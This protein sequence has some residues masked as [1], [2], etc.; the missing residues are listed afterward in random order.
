MIKPLTSLRFFFA[1]IVFC[2]HLSFFRN[3]NNETLKNIYYGILKEGYLGVSFF[4]ILSGFILAYNYQNKFLEKKACF[5][6]FVFARWARIYPLHLITFFIAI[7][8]T[9]SSLGESPYIWIKKALSNLFLIHSFS[10]D[11]STYFSFN[12]VSW[13]I[14][15]EWF[16]YIAFPFI[17]YLISKIKHTL[18]KILI[19]SVIILIPILFYILLPEN[20]KLHHSLFYVNPLFRVIDFFIGIFLFN[21]FTNQK[22]KSFFNK[23]SNIL[24]FSSL[25][26]FLLFFIFHKEVNQ[27]L[28]FSVYYWVPMSFIILTFAFQKGYL[29]RILSNKILIHLG[30]IS[31][32]VYMFHQLILRYLNDIKGEFLFI[33]NEIILFMVGLILTLIISHISHKFYETPVNKWLKKNFI[34]KKN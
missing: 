29:S 32:G 31:F 2:S 25:C 27:T 22:V 28:R 9:V 12:L 33:N 4:F 23:N 5:R 30:E 15:D 16:F 11:P 20:Q 10:G 8:Y 24:E 6:N 3:S 19:S 14:S 7:P 1:F 17:I 21:I 13:S 18:S 26:I 34:K